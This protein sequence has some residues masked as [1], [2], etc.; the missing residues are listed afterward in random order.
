MCKKRGCLWCNTEREKMSRMS[1]K[2]YEWKFSTNLKF[3]T[4]TAAAP[5]IGGG[6]LYGNIFAAATGFSNS[7]FSYFATVWRWFVFRF[8]ILWWFSWL[9]YYWGDAFNKPLLLIFSMFCYMYKYWLSEFPHYSMLF[10][11]G[12]HTTCSFQT[13]YQNTLG[14]DLLVRSRYVLRILAS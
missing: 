13:H 4:G 6:T 5:W 10:C 12:F 14:N 9:F 8:L 2:K 11:F 7:I 3:C 1:R